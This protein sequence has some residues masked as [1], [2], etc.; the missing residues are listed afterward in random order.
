MVGRTVSLRVDKT[1]ARPGEPL[2]EV[3]DLV[4]ED[5]LGVTRVKGVSFAVRR[6]EIVGVAGVAGN[7]QSELIEALAGI[8]PVK[9]GR[10]RW[11]GSTLADGPERSPRAM[12][13]LGLAHVPEDRQRMGLVMPFAARESAILGYHGEAA[14]NGPLWLRRGAVAAS[15]RRQAEDARHPAGGRRAAHLRLLGRQ[16]AEDRAGPRAGP[17]PRAPAGR[18]AHPGRR[19][20]RD[21]VHPPAPGGAPRRRHRRF[22]WSRSSSTRSSRWPTASW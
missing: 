7:G 20:R 14:Y 16:P 11:K 12:R 22:S 17:P 10:I 18:A 13:R 9:S 5:A 21:R 3:T 8:R 6:G 15:F 19:H 2:L 1:P 4:V